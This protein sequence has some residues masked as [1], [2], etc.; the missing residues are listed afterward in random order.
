MA[1]AAIVLGV[2]GAAVGAKARSW[3]PAAACR[4]RLSVFRGAVVWSSRPAGAA[5][6]PFWRGVCLS[7]IPAAEGCIIP[8]VF[9]LTTHLISPF[10]THKRIS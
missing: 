8:K 10:D 6:H 4:H 1:P 3:L 7:C 9:L 5:G 2:I